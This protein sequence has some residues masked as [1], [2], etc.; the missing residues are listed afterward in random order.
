MEKGGVSK[1]KETRNVDD[2][3]L[4][5]DSTLDSVT[6][7]VHQNAVSGLSFLTLISPLSTDS[8]YR[9]GFIDCHASP[10]EKWNLSPAIHWG[11]RRGYAWRKGTI[12]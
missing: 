3:A 4:H 6:L 1:R 5:G 8:T 9:G 10:E 2:G 7:E 12:G 11:Q